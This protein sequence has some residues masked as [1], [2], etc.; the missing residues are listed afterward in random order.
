LQTLHIGIVATSLQY[1]GS[2]RYHT[3]TESFNE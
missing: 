2:F 1:T 3:D